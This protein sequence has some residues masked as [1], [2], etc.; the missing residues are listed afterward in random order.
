MKLDNFI[1]QLAILFLPGVV[2]ARIDASWTRQTKPS[3]TEFFVRAFLFGL[4]CHAIVYTI[5]TLIGWPYEIV[6]L[7]ASAFF[8]PSIIKE[9]SFATLVGFLLAVLWLYANTYKWMARFLQFIGATRRYGDEDVWDFTF[10]SHAPAVQFAHFRDF[11]HEVVYAGF[12]NAFSEREGIREL[13]L[14]DVEVYDFAG[15]LMYDVPLLYL[16]RKAETIHI[17]FPHRS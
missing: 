10:N 17:E 14:R 2:W 15:T 1:I 8:T 11:E 5:F 16:S 9:I 7:D 3:D 6:K 13:V 12:V 4:T